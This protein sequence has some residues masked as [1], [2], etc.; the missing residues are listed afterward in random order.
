MQTKLVTVVIPI[1]KTN[2]KDWEQM[3]LNQC[4]KV[5]GAF[6]IVFAHPENLDVSSLNTDNK[7]RTEA[8]PDHYFKTVFGYNSLM[9]SQEFYQRFLDFKYMLVYQLDAFV[10][11]NELLEW[12]EKGYDYIGAPWIASPNTPLKKVL[13]LFDSKKKKERAKIFFKVGNG[14]F[15]L[16]NVTKSYEIAKALKAEI[17]VNLKRE[18]ND[19]YIMEDVFW[20]I[21][22]PKHYP[23]F[24]IPEYK[25][26]LDFA[27]DRKPDLAL[28]LN[29]NKL[30][31][32]CHGFDKPK[33]EAFWKDILASNYVG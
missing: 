1:Y 8:F 3:S 31:F 9:L 12:C 4:F 32:G 15:S 18:Q 7:A 6:D 30:P 21:T 13:S 11:K 26:A 24:K 2:L 33:V 16:R 27:M 23:D 5:L 14:G 29:N 20:S 25:E 19:F 17:E 10:F 28:K 22:V